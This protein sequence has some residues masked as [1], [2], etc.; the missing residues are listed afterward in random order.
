MN[1]LASNSK[2]LVTFGGAVLKINTLVLNSKQDLYKAQFLI[3]WE[4]WREN[5]SYNLYLSSRLIFLTLLKI[6]EE[7]FLFVFT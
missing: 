3:R 2:S 1:Y 4:N 5:Q 6:L 7:F